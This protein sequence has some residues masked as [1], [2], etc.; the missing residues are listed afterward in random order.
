VMQGIV[1]AARHCF[2]ASQPPRA[3]RS[4]PESIQIRSKNLFFRRNFRLSPLGFRPVRWTQPHRMDTSH[5]FENL[6]DV[7]QA[8][9]GFIKY[10]YA[11]YGTHTIARQPC[12]ARRSSKWIDMRIHH[13]LQVDT[14]TH[15]SSK[16][17]DM[18]IHHTSYHTC[19][20]VC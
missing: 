11:M 2:Q 8:G 12:D 18:P 4:Q 6:Q 14:L 16:W 17:I 5:I 7:T 1:C 3:T 9:L 10:R 13:K 20:R 15:I 19:E